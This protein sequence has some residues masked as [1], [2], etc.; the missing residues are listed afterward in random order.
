MRCLL[1]LALFGVVAGCA[2]GTASRYRANGHYTV[3]KCE[4]RERAPTPSEAD[5][6]RADERVDIV[7]E[8]KV[9]GCH[10]GTMTVP[11]HPHVADTSAPD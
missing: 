2:S 11:G 6:W 10:L 9:T 8:G 7:C 5:S 4:G 3:C 1:I